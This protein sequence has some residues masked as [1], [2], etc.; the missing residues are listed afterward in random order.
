MISRFA[1]L[2][3]AL[4]CV[5]CGGEASR[6]G[7]D[8]AIDEQRLD[9]S[10]IEASAEDGASEDASLDAIEDR[11]SIDVVADHPADDVSVE[12]S[13]DGRAD[14]RAD[15]AAQVNPLEGI[16]VVELVRAGFMFTEGPQW[17]PREGDLL[18]S[19]IPGDTIHRVQEPM[20]VSVFRRPSSNS[21]GLAIDEMGRLVAAEHGSRSVTR[22]RADGTRETLARDFMEGGTLRRLNSPND[23]VVRSDGTLYFTDPPYGIM[24]AEQELSFNGVFRRAPSG[25]LSAEWRGSRA[26]RP[27][28]IALSPDERTLYVTDTADGTVRAFDVA[29]DGA[30]SRERTLLSTSGNPDGMAVDRDGNLFVTTRTGVQVFSSSG[31]LWGTISIPMQPANCAFGGADGRTLYVTARSGLYRVRMARPGLY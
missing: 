23:L 20:A 3:V 24:A 9:A 21:N 16:G 8:A 6:D 18:F 4:G 15:A 19:D 25:A 7:G 31:R 30:L 2:A 29:A 12:A 5:A 1:V 14:A 10:S 27:N 13:L 22:T 26:S 28:G 11:S 17:R